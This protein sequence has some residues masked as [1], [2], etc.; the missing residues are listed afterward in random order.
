M[1]GVDPQHLKNG[2]THEGRRIGWRAGHAS[3]PADQNHEQTR[4][5]VMEVMAEEED[6]VLITMV[7]VVSRVVLLCR[8]RQSRRRFRQRLVQDQLWKEQLI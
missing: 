4:V 7:P 6:L 8:M 1:C 3:A 5:E 2:V